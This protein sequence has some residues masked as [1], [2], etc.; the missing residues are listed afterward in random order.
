MQLT[1]KKKQEEK[2]FVTYRRPVT[3]YSS[4]GNFDDPILSTFFLFSE[5]G[6]IELVFHEL[7]HTLFF[8]KNQVDLNENLATYF[9][10]K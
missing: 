4:L 8:V 1:F 9:S 7:Y 3:A 6:L 2:D 10:Q 5:K